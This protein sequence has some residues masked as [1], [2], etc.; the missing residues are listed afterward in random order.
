MFGAVLT[1]MGNML[2]LAEN[3]NLRQMPAPARAA[4]PITDLAKVFAQFAQLQH[5]F[6]EQVCAL[7]ES[8]GQERKQP[9]AQLP[10]LKKQIGWLISRTKGPGTVRA[11]RS[12]NRGP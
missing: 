11:E 1:R 7:E 9:A 8:V 6:G 10:E 3:D 2:D 5:Q 12:G 4:R